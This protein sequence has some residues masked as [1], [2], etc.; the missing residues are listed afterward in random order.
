[1]IQE[2]NTECKYHLKSHWVWGVVK[3]LHVPN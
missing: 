3:Q 2:Y 1:M